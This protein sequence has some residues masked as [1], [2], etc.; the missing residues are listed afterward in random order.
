MVDNAENNNDPLRDWESYFSIKQRVFSLESMLL[1]SWIFQPWTPSNGRSTHSQAYNDGGNS[2]KAWC[3]R[4][5]DDREHGL[6][7]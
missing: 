6:K 7:I 2:S 4:T 1:Q 3:Y 5:R